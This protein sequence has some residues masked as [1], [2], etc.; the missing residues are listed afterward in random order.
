LH[1]AATV[2]HAEHTED[3]VVLTVLLSPELYDR[4][5]EYQV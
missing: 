5:R 1:E 2:E 3:G 4:Y